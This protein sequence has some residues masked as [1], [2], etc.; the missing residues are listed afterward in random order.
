[1]T[2]LAVMK[3]GMASNAAG[4]QTAP[5]IVFHGDADTTVNARNGEQV[6]A[7]ARAGQDGISPTASE[8]SGQSAHGRSFTR[9]IDADAQGRPL[10]EHWLLHGA[11]HAWAGGSAQG[12]FT[13]PTGPDASAEMLRF[14]MAHANIAATVTTTAG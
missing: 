8:S 14:F 11:G 3:H 9:R 12:S 2:A 5:T 7:A 13:D 1:M 6:A 4:A 10:V